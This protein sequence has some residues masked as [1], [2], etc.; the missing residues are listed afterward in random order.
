MIMGD[1]ELGEPHLLG[2]NA[3]CS[4]S[5][6]GLI[7]IWVRTVAGLGEQH[8]VISAVLIVWGLRC[9]QLAVLNKHQSLGSSPAVSLSG[10]LDICCSSPQLKPSLYCSPCP[11]VRGLCF[12][13]V[14][15]QRPYLS[16]P[17]C[18][19]EPGLWKA[20]SS[21]LPLSQGGAWHLPADGEPL[22][23]S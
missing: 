21:E 9:F 5:H 3:S 23:E 20:R 19:V 17:M 1:L 6:A 8:M 7:F 11:Y 13:H 10:M 2:N 4:W 16:S 22:V 18:G 14:L 15:E 12:L